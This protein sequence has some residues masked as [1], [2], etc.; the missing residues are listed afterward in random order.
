MAVLGHH[1]RVFCN[2]AYFVILCNFPLKMQNDQMEI[3]VWAYIGS[4]H[5]A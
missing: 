2:L 4:L 5:K 1:R 3:P